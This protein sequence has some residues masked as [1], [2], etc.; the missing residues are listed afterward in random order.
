MKEIKLRGECILDE[1]TIK[2]LKDDIR[3]EV[4]YEI[5]E[6]WFRN[7]DEVLVLYKKLSVQRK[8]HLIAE[9]LDTIDK[10]IKTENYRDEKNLSIL[11]LL[12]KELKLMGI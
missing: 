8:L 7:S 12:K 9:M 11:L 1:I 10:N 6:E 2:E 4:I 3:K 5:N